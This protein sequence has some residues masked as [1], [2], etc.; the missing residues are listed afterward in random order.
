MTFEEYCEEYLDLHIALMSDEE[1][2]DARQAYNKFIKPEKTPVE[3]EKHKKA[4]A[5]AKESRKLAKF[6]GGK[7]L[8]GSA[9]QKKWAESIREDVLC[10]NELTDEQKTELI[11]LGSFL[12]TSKFWINNRNTKHSNL[13]PESIV[14]QY[15]MLKALNEKHYDTL[16]KS[17]D[18]AKKD[19]ARK[20]IYSALSS[21]TVIIDFKYPNCDFYD[22]YGNLKKGLT[23]RC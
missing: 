12:N 15:K 3:I 21:L 16:A 5:A 11:N 9:K 4:L 20:E 14:D 6:Y 13:N 18:L 22:S 1:I 8:T 19:L 2:K 23:F 7:A 10:S 17:H